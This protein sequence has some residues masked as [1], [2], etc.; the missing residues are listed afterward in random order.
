MNNAI[1]DVDLSIFNE[2]LKYDTNKFI[3]IC[4]IKSFQVFVREFWET[5]PGAGKLIWN[6]HMVYF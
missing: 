6:W 4:C 5:V 2:H 3:N 1:A